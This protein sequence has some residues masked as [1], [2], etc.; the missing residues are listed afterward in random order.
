MIHQPDI[1]EVDRIL[2]RTGRGADAVIPA[3]QAIQRQYRYLP[4]EALRHLCANSDITPAA[5]ESVA[6]FF[7]QFRRRP[8]GEHIISVC[9]GTACHVKGAPAV[10]DAVAQRLGLNG[11]EDT[12][13]AA[14][15][16]PGPQADD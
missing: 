14:Q 2:D 3:L 4:E 5:V 11:N 8:V 6:T 13:A 12:D 16:V 1:A 15:L 10:Y 9:D 7:S